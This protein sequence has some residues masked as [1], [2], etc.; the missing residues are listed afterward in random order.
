MLGV[1]STRMGGFRAQRREQIACAPWARFTMAILKKTSGTR[2]K[3]PTHKYGGQYGTFCIADK[4]VLGPQG[5]ND[6]PRGTTHVIDQTGCTS[7]LSMFLRTN[8][9]EIHGLD[10]VPIFDTAWHKIHGSVIVQDS[11]TVRPTGC[12]F[13]YCGGGSVTNFIQFNTSKRTGKG[14]NPTTHVDQLVC[15]RKQ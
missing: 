12:F 6:C 10:T 14:F 7:A 11:G 5:T 1:A 15:Y 8:H 4:Y 13:T 9:H 3:S 2:R